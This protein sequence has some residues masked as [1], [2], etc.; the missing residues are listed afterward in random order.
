MLIQML[1]VL[2]YNYHWG[3]SV[4][5]KWDYAMIENNLMYLEVEEI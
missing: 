4:A 3:S 1:I 5:A 2:L